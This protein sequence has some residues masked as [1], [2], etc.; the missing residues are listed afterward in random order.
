MP[1][2]EKHIHTTQEQTIWDHFE[3]GRMEEIEAMR[4]AA[5]AADQRP[6]TSPPPKDWMTPIA[7][8]QIDRKN[9]YA[10]YQDVHE[11]PETEREENTRALVERENASL[12]SEVTV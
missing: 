10:H 3:A 11:I 5:Q 4:S 8:F 12:E 7:Q 2:E 1:M 9:A 6:P